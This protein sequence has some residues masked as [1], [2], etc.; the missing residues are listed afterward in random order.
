[1]ALT[2]DATPG[3]ETAN[4]YATLAEMDAFL[5]EKINFFPTWSAFPDQTKFAYMISATRAI[6]RYN[7]RGVPVNND[8]ALKFPTTTQLTSTFD[9]AAEI[10]DEVKRAQGEMIIYLVQGVD[11]ST[12]QVADEIAE[13]DVFEQVR[14]KYRD[15]KSNSSAD[16]A[17]GGNLDAVEAELREWLAGENSFDVVK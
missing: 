11:S 2:L 5:E 1:M 9:P 4:T 15:F 14:I 12:G 8:Q 6:D 13:V 3:G 10:P 7:I 17:A 16:Q